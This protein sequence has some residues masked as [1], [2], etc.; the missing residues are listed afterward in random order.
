MRN[1]FRMI[2]GG[3]GNVCSDAQFDGLSIETVNS[4]NSHVAASDKI[5]P[6]KP[7]CTLTSSTAEEVVEEIKQKFRRQGVL[8]PALEM[9]LDDAV[10]QFHQADPP[11]VLIVFATATM[12]NNTLIH[13][14]TKPDLSQNDIGCYARSSGDLLLGNGEEIHHFMDSTCIFYHPFSWRYMAMRMEGLRLQW[15][16]E[17]EGVTK[18]AAYAHVAA[19]AYPTD[20]T[21]EFITFADIVYNAGTR[22]VDKQA[23]GITSVPSSTRFSGYYQQDRIGL[24]D[25]AFDMAPYAYSE[26]AQAVRK[27]ETG[28]SMSASEQMD[29]MPIFIVQKSL[30][31]RAPYYNG[32][33]RTDEGSVRLKLYE[34]V[35]AFTINEFDHFFVKSPF[36]RD[37]ALEQNQRYYTHQER[38]CFTAAEVY[39]YA[40]QNIVPAMW[41]VDEWFE[42]RVGSRFG[43]LMYG[44]KDIGFCCQYSTSDETSH[45]LASSCANGSGHW[46]GLM[47]GVEA[48]VRPSSEETYFENGPEIQVGFTCATSENP[49]V[50]CKIDYEAHAVAVAEFGFRLTIRNWES[51]PEQVVRSAIKAACQ[52]TV[53]S[54]AEF[55][56]YRFDYILGKVGDV[57]V[58]CP[59]MD[60]KFAMRAESV[61]QLL[62]IDVENDPL[63][64]IVEALKEG[65]KISIRVDPMADG[66]CAMMN[67]FDY[68]RM[69]EATCSQAWWK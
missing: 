16:L 5:K 49:Y 26:D 7:L 21:Q 9:T 6:K 53:K 44:G 62:D 33:D 34:A 3:A 40:A 14:R 29:S 43:K 4:R 41:S 37:I 63:E 55:I 17:Y 24:P 25:Q 58:Y 69:N 11:E 10:A 48:F 65:I 15:E 64:D 51:A 18:E 31:S 50:T 60:G 57:E 68:G 61:V 36:L 38:T 67:D 28:S 32:E 54:T 66:T 19:Q 30:A 8:D 12:L 52:E 13:F 35:T 27:I 56:G 45:H 2:D 42:H 46:N 1:S 59:K 47:T 39:A 20:S 22:I 23:T